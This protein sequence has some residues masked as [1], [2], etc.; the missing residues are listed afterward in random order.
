MAAILNNPAIIG[1]ASAMPTS[2]LHGHPN[3]VSL[4]HERASLAPATV[5][6]LELTG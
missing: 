5:G 3:A 4:L 1:L 6:A 2:L